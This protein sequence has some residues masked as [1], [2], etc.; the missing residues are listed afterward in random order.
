MKNPLLQLL[1]VEERSDGVYIR[2]IRDSNKE[3]LLKAIVNALEGALVCNYDTEAIRDVVT[4]ARGLFER[5]GP[6]LIYYNPAFDAFAQVT[7]ESLSA[8]LQINSSCVAEGL[9]PSVEELRYCLKRQGVV[10]GILDDQL[11]ALVHE[12]LYDKTLEIAWGKKPVNGRDGT[13]AYEIEIAHDRRPALL[14]NGNVDYRSIKSFTQVSGGQ[15]IAKK[16]PPTPGI[17]GYAVNGR[18][19]AA[20][21]GKDYE[22][23]EGENIAISADGNHLVAVN[24]GV[25]YEDEG[26]LH[27]KQNLEIAHDV[28][29]TVGNVRFCGTVEVQGNVLP[30]FCIESDENIIIHGEV[31]AATV[32]SRNGTVTIRKGVIGKGDARIFA[33]K[34]IS[35]SFAQNAELFTEGELVVDRSLLHCTCRCDSFDMV[36]RDGVVIGGVVEAYRAVE[37]MQLGS[38][39][40]VSTTVRLVDKTR[41]ALEQKRKEVVM[42]RDE[43]ALQLEPIKKQLST[44]AAMLQK[45]GTVVTER[46]KAELKKWLDSFNALKVKYDY[47]EKKIA[48]IDAVLSTPV[49]CEGFVKVSGDLWPG[50]VIELYGMSKKITEHLFGKRIV[51]RGAEVSVEAEG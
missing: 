11:Q 35:V 20:L 4:R 7:A 8:T 19:I 2:V 26:I 29:F 34:G 32:R 17:A 10:Y 38:Q 51:S 23:R 42:V 28:D 46:V 12:G 36:R 1:S 5:I 41:L 44:K 30:G 3:T 45:S 24:S 18:E 21:V 14:P 6:P 40:G 25:I 33:K 27:I 22:L 16:T 13:I 37:L 39:E 43:L 31:E 49:K 15:I 47:V 50:A 9:R 48:D